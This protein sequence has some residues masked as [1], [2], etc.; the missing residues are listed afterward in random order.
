MLLF[1][2]VEDDDEKRQNSV[3]VLPQRLLSLCSSVSSISQVLNGHSVFPTG[4]GAEYDSSAST[5]A[6][7]SACYGSRYGSSLS[8]IKRSQVCA[9]VVAAQCSTFCNIESVGK[10][11]RLS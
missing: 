6:N 1:L 4:G 7:E 3:S 11:S 2:G 5:Y 10:L 9:S 8:K